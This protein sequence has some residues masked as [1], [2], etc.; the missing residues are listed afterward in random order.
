MRAALGDVVQDLQSQ[1]K[2][3]AAQATS[4]LGAIETLKADA[5]AAQRAWEQQRD[6]MSAAHMGTLAEVKAAHDAQTAGLRTALHEVMCA[7]ACVRA[8]VRE[9]GRGRECVCV[10]VY[11]RV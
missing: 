3:S 9:R 7:C 6:Q 4:A 1:L 10:F 11:L 2:A 8:C 5:L